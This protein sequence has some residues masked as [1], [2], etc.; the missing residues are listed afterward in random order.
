MKILDDCIKFEKFASMTLSEAAKILNVPIVADKDEISKAYKMLAVKYHPDVYKEPD[1]NHK[2]VQLNLAREIL[3]AEAEKNIGKKLKFEVSKEQYTRQEPTKIS[4]KNLPK[5][6]RNALKSIGYRKRDIGI[7]YSN[8]VKL[9]SRSYFDYAR[10]YV[11]TIDL[12]SGKTEVEYG[13]WGG[14][15]FTSSR[16]DVDERIY[17]VPEDM[18]F[19]LGKEGGTSARIATLILAPSHKDEIQDVKKLAVDHYGVDEETGEAKFPK[20]EIGDIVVD[21]HGRRAKY[22]GEAYWMDK[23]YSAIKHIDK[24][25]KPIGKVDKHLTYVR[26]NELVKEFRF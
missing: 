1:A 9:N 14:P 8:N 4:T 3:N 22:L 13:D 7:V 26:T 5:V 16:V 2:M 17:N 11:A 6:I 18:A 24:Y 20:F 25:N 12:I 10:G 23:G 15:S 21:R 19:V